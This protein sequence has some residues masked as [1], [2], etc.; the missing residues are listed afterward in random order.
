MLVPQP[1]PDPMRRVPLLARRLPVRFQHLLDMLF[2]RSQ[3]RLFPIGLLPVRRDR[4]R[5]R[6]AHHP[7]VNAML[8]SKALDRLSG[9]VP[10]PDLF[11]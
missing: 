3:P 8:P 1:G 11:K 10:M 7:P 6:L 5:D 9:C 2:D 4:A